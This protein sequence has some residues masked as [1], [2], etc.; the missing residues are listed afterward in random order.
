MKNIQKEELSQEVYDLFD[1][2]VHNKIDRRKFVNKLAIHAVGGLT[3][4]SMMSFL[5]P[6]YAEAQKI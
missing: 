5:L 3:V 2:Y 4:T 6:K 1:S